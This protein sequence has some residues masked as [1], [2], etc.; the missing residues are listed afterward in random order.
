MGN[1]SV[2][3]V[4]TPLVH[5]PKVVKSGVVV[6]VY[7][8]FVVCVCVLKSAPLAGVVRPALRYR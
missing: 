7:S 1:S 8:Y 3:T 6:V 2:S 5:L 4:F